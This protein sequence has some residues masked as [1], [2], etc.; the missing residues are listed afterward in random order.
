MT[1]PLPAH[2]S[3]SG[4]S[5]SA[6]HSMACVL[7]GP[8]WSQVAILDI[9][10]NR[11]GALCYSVVSTNLAYT[12]WDGVGVV[13]GVSC[14]MFAAP[15]LEGTKVVVSQPATSFKVISPSRL[16]MI[17]DGKHY[18]SVNPPYGGLHRAEVA[19]PTAQLAPVH[20]R[21]VQ[22]L[23]LI[24]PSYLNRVSDVD[25]SEEYQDLVLQLDNSAV[26]LPPPFWD[27]LPP[28]D[29]PWGSGPIN[30][31]MALSINDSTRPLTEKIGHSQN[32]TLPPFFEGTSQYHRQLPWGDATMN[33]GI[34][35]D[36]TED[37]M[38]HTGLL[39]KRAAACLVN[40]QMPLHI[41]LET[42]KTLNSDT[43]E[44]DRKAI[45]EAATLGLA[46]TGAALQAITE[47][48]LET[49]THRADRLLHSLP[50]QDPEMIAR[51]RGRLAAQGLA[52]DYLLS[53]SD[54]Q[55]IRQQVAGSAPP[56]TDG[57]PPDHSS[58]HSPAGPS[59]VVAGTDVDN[60]TEDIPDE[61]ASTSAQTSE[62]G[63]AQV[64]AADYEVRRSG[65][66]SSQRQ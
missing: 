33:D 15:R 36:N 57:T 18:P 24:N 23:R 34:E 2:H 25:E 7:L 66:I 12:F 30:R 55:L 17:L 59:E 3:I 45:H 58:D 29:F 32:I 41:I 50:V 31:T 63:T 4:V 51:V 28:G 38:A 56:E 5:G 14:V 8:D 54:G 1:G 62:E 65:R 39:H 19:S 37:V 44:H 26:S 10:P 16:L 13:P 11:D 42:I 48:A 22:T 43:L 21:V 53:E 27:Q 52:A 49:V 61:L 35:L 64:S 9:A 6:S 40:I 20:R 60:N 47:S 46:S